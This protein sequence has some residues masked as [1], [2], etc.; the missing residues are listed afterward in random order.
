MGVGAA[1]SPAEKT[2]EAEVRRQASM[3]TI[4]VPRAAASGRVGS[5]SQELAVWKMQQAF[6]SN[7]RISEGL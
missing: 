6:V 3:F 7:Q 5:E 2:S 1:R 4:F